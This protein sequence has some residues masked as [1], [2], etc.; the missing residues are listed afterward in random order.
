MARIKRVIAV[1]VIS[2]LLLITACGKKGP[3]IIEAPAAGDLLRQ[4]AEA[5]DK[6]RSFH[7]LLE[8][9]NGATPIVL[10]VM[11]ERAEGDVLKP[12][13]VQADVIGRLQAVSVRTRVIGVGDRAW[14]TNP[15]T[16]TLQTLD[17]GTMI[18]QVFDPAV[19]VRRVVAAIQEPRLTGSETVDGVETLIV[20]GLVDSG[21]LK[22]IAPFAQP[23][24]QVRVRAWLGKS[25][26]LPRRLRLEGPLAPDEPANIARRLTLSKFNEQVSIEPPP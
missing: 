2:S 8:H 1:L 13:R 12:D 14:I 3:A 4:A 18:A 11:M 19:G 6:T 10:G 22:A 20:E 23:G 16:Q 9:E 5:L 25:D 26:T 24:Q 15:F 21:E 17:Q 7:F